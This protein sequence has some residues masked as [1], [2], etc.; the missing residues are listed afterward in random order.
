VPPSAGRRWLSLRLHVSE[1]KL[2]AQEGVPHPKW[3]CEDHLRVTANRSRLPACRPRSPCVTCLTRPVTSSRP[4]PRRPDDRSRSTSVARSS[5]SRGDRTR[6]RR[7]T[8]DASSAAGR[9]DRRPAPRRR[10]RRDLPGGGEPGARAAV[11]RCRFHAAP[12]AE[13]ESAGADWVFLPE[14]Y[15]ALAVTARGRRVAGT[16]GRRS[17]RPANV[18][19]HV[20]GRSQRPGP[21][22]VDSPA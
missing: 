15:R 18:R 17:A 20:V 3:I 13:A 6:R 11:P 21:V 1:R 8:R 4:G 12:F 5:C 16:A 7:R 9:G 22:P 2:F 14:L 19:R 10:Q